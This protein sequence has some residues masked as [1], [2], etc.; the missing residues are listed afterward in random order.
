[1][2]KKPIHID[3]IYQEF[4]IFKD[5]YKVW[6]IL[7]NMDDETLWRLYTFNNHDVIK[8]RKEIWK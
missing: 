3:K 1:M 5:Y 8:L 7:K 4:K 2:N 6:K